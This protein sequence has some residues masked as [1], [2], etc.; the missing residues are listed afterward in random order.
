VTREAG[1]VPAGAL[2]SETRKNFSNMCPPTIQRILYGGKS[3][4]TGNLRAQL[5]AGFGDAGALSTG[6]RQFHNKGVEFQNA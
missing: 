4:K 2:Y 3:R 1:I 5:T 6:E